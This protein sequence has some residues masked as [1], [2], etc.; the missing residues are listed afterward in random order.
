VHC[1][2][3]EPWQ[4]SIGFVHRR[5]EEAGRVGCDQ[6]LCRALGVLREQS[7]S[8]ALGCAT[9]TARVVR[10]PILGPIRSCEARIIM[11]AG[12]P[13]ARRW[14]GSHHGPLI[15]CGHAAVWSQQRCTKRGGASGG[16]SQQRQGGEA[17]SARA[18]CR[19]G[20]NSDS[21]CSH[22]LDDPAMAEAREC[23]HAA[24]VHA[25]RLRPRRHPRTAAATCAAAREA[26]A[27]LTAACT[28][29]CTAA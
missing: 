9:C 4:L 14:W 13:T 6:P 21:S 28:A 18:R 1:E 2:R 16:W 24:Q 5:D 7:R 3:C 10:G 8:V 29:A 15:S 11:C 12:V 17:A 23:L 20:P 22:L 25:E 19:R 26:A 27:V